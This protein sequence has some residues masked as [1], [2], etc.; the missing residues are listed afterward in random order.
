[1]K[2]RSY[3]EDAMLISKTKRAFEQYVFAVAQCQ[4]NKLVVYVFMFVL[5]MNYFT[6]LIVQGETAVTLKL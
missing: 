2:N 4:G 1:M 3:H 5:F 6:V